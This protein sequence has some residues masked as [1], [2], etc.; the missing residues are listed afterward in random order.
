MVPHAK[1]AEVKANE[2]HERWCELLGILMLTEELTPCTLDQ[3][4]GMHR[5]VALTQR[6]PSDAA[7]CGRKTSLPEML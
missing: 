3:I 2:W 6:R 1:G 4:E 5:G 7:S